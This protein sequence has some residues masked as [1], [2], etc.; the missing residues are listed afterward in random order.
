MRSMQW[1]DIDFEN[2]MITIAAEVM[3]NRKIHV[4]PMSP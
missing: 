3:N 4:V 1:A 2:D